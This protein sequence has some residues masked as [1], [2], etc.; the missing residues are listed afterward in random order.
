MFRLVGNGKSGEKQVLFT[1]KFVIDGIPQYEVELR[2]NLNFRIVEIAHFV[3]CN[4]TNHPDKLISYLES[5][6]GTRTTNTVPLE[7][8]D[9]ISM[10][11]P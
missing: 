2:L 10:V 3:S 11:P 9:S 7:D 1:G 5:G 6:S 4:L 8:V